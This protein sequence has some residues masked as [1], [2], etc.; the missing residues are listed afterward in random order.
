MPKHAA[1]KRKPRRSKISKRKTRR[2]NRK[3]LTKKGGG[4]DPPSGP[5]PELGTIEWAKWATRD[6]WVALRKESAADRYRILFPAIF[7]QNTPSYLK[8]L[9]VDDDITIL[10][11]KF[12]HILLQN[13]ADEDVKIKDY[14]NAVLE[15]ELYE[16]PESKKHAR[17]APDFPDSRQQILL[18][19]YSM[20]WGIIRIIAY[21]S[22]KRVSQHHQKI[23]LWS[24]GR[25]PGLGGL[26]VEAHGAEDLNTPA[27]REL[28][29]WHDGL[30]SFEKEKKAVRPSWPDKKQQQQRSTETDSIDDSTRTADSPAADAH[31]NPTKQEECNWG[32][33]C[34][35][36]FT[37]VKGISKSGCRW[38]RGKCMKL[39]APSGRPSGAEGGARKRKPRRSKKIS[40]R[41]SK[42]R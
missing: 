21:E 16:D 35:E 12:L 18:H 3:N 11:R 9:F 2:Y 13:R 1:S 24:E 36:G 30:K 27:H 29:H 10:V 8:L 32:T 40:K 38:P 14:D 19:Y 26:R 41:V 25:I 20:F 4:D 42:K 31:A 22:N 23:A 6:D 5:P 37:F 34:S 7:R 33:S 15:W 28:R 17:L 39:Y